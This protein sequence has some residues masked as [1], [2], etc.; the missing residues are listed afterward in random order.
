MEISAG[1]LQIIVLLYFQSHPLK[2]AFCVHSAS[3]AFEVIWSK[4][5]HIQT[6]I[7]LSRKLVGRNL[8]GLQT[9]DQNGNDK[10][11]SASVTWKKGP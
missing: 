2:Q 4:G 9:E 3:S 7:D 1:N 10:V 8:L 5:L 11:P 6:F